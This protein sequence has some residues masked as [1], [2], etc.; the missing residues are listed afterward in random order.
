MKRRSPRTLPRGRVT[1]EL[2]KSRVL[3]GNP[4][5]DPAV[6]EVPVYLPPGYDDSTRTRYPVIFVL[7]GFTGKGR[8]LLNR[9]GFGEAIDERMDRLIGE[10]R[11]AP[12]ILVMPD[13]FTRFGGSQYLNSSATGRYEDHLTRE[14]IPW[15]DETFRTRPEAA[16]RG[17]MGKSSGGYGALVLGMRHPGLFG[18][19]ASHSGDAY[20]EYCYLP[21]FPKAVNGLRKHGGISGFLKAFERAPKKTHDLVSTLNIVAMAA[22]YSPNPRSPHRFDLPFDIGTGRLDERVWQRWLL[23]DPIRLVS[24]HASSLRGM[25]LVYLDAGLRDEWSLHLGARILAEAFKKHRV[26]HVHEEFDD[27]HM[28]VSY[29]YDASLPRLTAALH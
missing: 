2:F 3:A 21:D 22:C 13:A 27:G 12:A 1:I 28:G 14:L 10:R 18:A 24:R 25:R 17:V 16:H 15:V 11:A 19:V 9:D 7:T 4:L 26:P 6:R 20:F 8:M 29:R 5:G 23:C